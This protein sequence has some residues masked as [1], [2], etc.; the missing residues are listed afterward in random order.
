[1]RARALPPAAFPAT[2][3]ADG[4]RKQLQL[5]CGP[6]RPDC[7]SGAHAR[8]HAPESPPDAHLPADLRFPPAISAQGVQSPEFQVQAR[9]VKGISQFFSVCL[10]GLP[11]V[12]MPLPR[13]LHIMA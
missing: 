10:Q 6:L 2:T 7:H 9:L 12:A 4:T 13:V 1:M 8:P 5:P 3:P 11:T